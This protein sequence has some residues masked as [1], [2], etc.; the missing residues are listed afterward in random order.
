ML[1]D[2]NKAFRFILVVV[3]KLGVLHRLTASFAMACPNTNGEQAHKARYPYETQQ[4]LTNDWRYL[5]FKP[6]L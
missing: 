3:I 4:L 2:H 1:R 6:Q 5:M